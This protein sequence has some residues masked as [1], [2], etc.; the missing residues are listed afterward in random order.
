[1]GCL[2]SSDGANPTAK[3]GLAKRERTDGPPSVD[4]WRLPPWVT[5]LVKRGRGPE[6]GLLGLAPPLARASDHSTTF[7]M[8]PIRSMV[9]RTRSPGLRKMPRPLPTPAGV[10]VAIT[11]PG[12]RVMNCE[13]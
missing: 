10:P 4:D 5:N 11:S 1:M 6:L 3:T 12:A 13:M 9:V 2:E 7:S 8:E